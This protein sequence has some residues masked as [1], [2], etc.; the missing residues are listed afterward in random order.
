[1]YMDAPSKQE[2]GRTGE[3]VS[4]VGLG[5]WSIR[6]YKRAFEVF[7]EALNSGIDNIDTAEMYDSGRAEE[8]AGRVVREVGKEN[9]FITTKMLPSHLVSRD[10]V[11]KASKASLRRLGLDTVDL[12]LI[13]WLNPSLPIEVQARNFEAVVEEGLSRYIGVS[14]FDID[15]LREAVASTKKADIVVNQVHYSVYHRYLVERGLG[16]FCVKEG[17]TIQAYTPIER[18][19]VAKDDLLKRIASQYDKTPIQVALNYVVSHPKVI[20][21]IKTENHNHLIEI[22]GSLGWNLSVEDIRLIQE[23]IGS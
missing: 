14:N 2:I 5:T 10:Q 11:I 21:I 20:A 16:D 19:R 7:V 17:I 23:K 9:V 8:F 22:L 4:S 13:H 18:G 12:F 6:D 1:M 3:Y 15:E